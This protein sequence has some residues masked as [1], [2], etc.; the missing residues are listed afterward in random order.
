MPLAPG[1]MASPLSTKTMPSCPP[2]AGSTGSIQ[3]PISSCDRAVPP[4]FLWQENIE[5]YAYGVHHSLLISQAHAANSSSGASV[6]NV[7]R[8]SIGRALGLFRI[9]S[10]FM[11]VVT[12]SI[13]N[14]WVRR[15][16]D[17]SGGRPR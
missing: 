17:F 9:G 6:P 10:L 11:A 14:G 12:R 13:A 7:R 2:T 5:A 8:S 15:I 1:R 3:H 16:G 4:A